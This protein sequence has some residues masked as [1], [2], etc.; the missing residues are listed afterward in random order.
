VSGK[1][2]ALIATAAAG[3]AA[4]LGFRAGRLAAKAEWRI[5]ASPPT[6]PPHAGGEGA[7]DF[8]EWEQAVLPR[9]S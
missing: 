6:A 1:E 9:D 3:A 8:S 4:V 5:G 7:S 2:C